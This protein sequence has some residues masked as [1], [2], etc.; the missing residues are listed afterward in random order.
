MW[1]GNK[2]QAKENYMTTLSF[3][4][5]VDCY[6]NICEAAIAA[7][8]EQYQQAHMT[9]AEWEAIMDELCKARPEWAEDN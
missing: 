6:D 4:E 9:Y 5:W 8:A 2:Q 7:M 1:S 3:N